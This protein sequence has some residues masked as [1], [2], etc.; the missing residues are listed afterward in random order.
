[1]VTSCKAAF[2]TWKLHTNAQHFVTE[3]VETA[4]ERPYQVSSIF[5]PSPVWLNCTKESRTF[6][7]LKYFVPLKV[8]YSEFS[9]KYALTDYKR[10]QE[11]YK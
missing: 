6:H 2:I 9:L 5:V 7:A 3:Y 1:M 8:N 11:C 10:P 4:V